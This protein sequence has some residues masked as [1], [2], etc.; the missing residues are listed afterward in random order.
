MTLSQRIDE[1]VK[2]RLRASRK[3]RKSFMKSPQAA[4]KWLIEMG[5]LEK[6]GKRLAK[7]YR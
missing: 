7:R 5:I 4:R 1:D 2:Q 3:A 6:S